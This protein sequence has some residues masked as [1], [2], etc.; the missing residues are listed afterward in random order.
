MA[1]FHY[2]ECVLPTHGQQSPFPESGRSPAEL[3]WISM[4]GPFSRDRRALLHEPS[5]T[6]DQ[7][8]ASEGI[9]RKSGEEKS[10]F[11][12]VLDGRELAVD[13][14]SYAPS[15]GGGLRRD[16]TFIEYSKNLID[17]LHP[18]YTFEPEHFAV[19]AITRSTHSLHFYDSVLA[20][21]KRLLSE[22]TQ[23]LTGKPSF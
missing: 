2:N 21:E 8:L 15:F 5:V 18:W 17:R 3:F 23:S 16:G 9:A 7:R 6:D 20:I 4:N 13:G 14:P 10:G 19:D 12:N 1:A 11:G 22:P